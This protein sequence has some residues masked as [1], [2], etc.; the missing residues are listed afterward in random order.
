[1]PRY[2]VRI[3]SSYM[4][5]Y[6][7]EAASPEAAAD[8]ADEYQDIVDMPKPGEREQYTGKV[9][10]VAK[11]EYVDHDDTFINELDAD[12]NWIDA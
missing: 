1:M 3:Y 4:D 5:E 9:K 7:V 8:L 10:Q 2:S 11:H 12:G 6:E